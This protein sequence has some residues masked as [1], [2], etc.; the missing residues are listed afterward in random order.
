MGFGQTWDDEGSIGTG[1]LA[2]GYADW[3]LGGHTDLELSVDFLR[4]KR[5]GGHFQAEGH[6]TFLG[7]SVVRRFGGRAASGYV[8]GGVT[9][10]AHSGTAGFPEVNL[11]TDTTGTH[12]GFLFGGGM[13]FRAGPRIEI[14]PVVRI[15]LLSVDNDS[16][17]ASAA[18]AGF[19]VGFGR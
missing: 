11:I 13:A 14:G 2:G 19:R 9:L 7:A 17:P 5:A 1:A 18:M 10:G 3:R 4:H 16:A 8:L 6:T 15:V 12:R